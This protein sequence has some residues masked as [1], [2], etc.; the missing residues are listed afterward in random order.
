MPGIAA[1]PALGTA[2]FADVA[3][4][5]SRYLEIGEGE[6][7]LL[8][9]GWIGSAENFHKWMP[10]LEGRRRVIIPDLPGFGETPPLGGRHSIEELGGWLEEFVDA[11]RL[12][13]FD[14][15]GLCLGGTVALEFARRRPGAVRQLVLHTPIYSDRAIADSFKLQT[16]LLLSGVIYPLASRLSRSRRVSDLY[17]RFLVEGEG[18]DDFDAA[19]NFENQRRCSPRAA[20]EWL[21]DAL[22]QNYESF[23]AAWPRPLMMVVAADDRLLDHDAMRRLCGSM[24][25]ARVVTIPDAGHGW[26]DAL[27][28]AQ[29][30]ALRDFLTPGTA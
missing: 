12:E 21:H 18:V 14:L 16:R 10:A 28:E 15:G 13:S 3:G 5:R 30:D 27:V 20:R 11:I 23:L 6:P 26:T 29:A 7:L 24:P 19:V 22:R 1:L 8:V 4:R 17:K 2:R 9:H 25:G